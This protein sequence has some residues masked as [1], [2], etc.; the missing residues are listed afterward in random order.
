MLRCAV[1]RYS[2]R[3]RPMIFGQVFPGFP[4]R[5]CCLTRKKAGGFQS[6]LPYRHHSKRTVDGLEPLCCA[7]PPGIIP[8]GRGAGGFQSAFLLC[9]CPCPSPRGQERRLSAA[10]Q[11]LPAGRLPLII[12]CRA[13]QSRL[14][15][16][17]NES[18]LRQDYTE[19]K[20]DCFYGKAQDHPRL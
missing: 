3:G 4:C 8:C 17:Y 1:R 15:V 18:S 20:G 19:Y 13:L 6:A 7:V 12:F 14:P 16:W 11:P 9:C 2:V 5:R 10:V